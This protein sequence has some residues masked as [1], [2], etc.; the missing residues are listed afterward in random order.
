[1]TK[2]KAHP[3]LLSDIRKYGKFDVNGC[4]SCGSCT[5]SCALSTDFAS[6]PRRMMRYVQ[7]GLKDEV[8][9]GLEPW[10]CYFCGDCSE[11][12]PREADPGESMMTLRRYLTAQYD[13]TG[14]SGKI[15]RSKLWE[16]GTLVLVAAAVLVLG[17]LVHQS[18][19]TSWLEKFLRADLSETHPCL[20]FLKAFDWTVLFLIAFFVLS[21]VIRM[22]W[23]TV[24]RSG[25]RVP[26]T[27]YVTELKTLFYHAFSQVGFRRCEG[28]GRRWISHLLLASGCGV[29]FVLVFGF[30]DWFQTDSVYPVTHPQRWLGYLATGAILFGAGDALWGRI[31]KR[32][33]VH[34]TS[35][36]G[37][38]VLPVLLLLTAL[39][40][41][42]IHILRYAEQY[43]WSNDLYAAHMAVAV[44]MLLVE[45]PFGKWAHMFYRPLAVYFQAL[46]ERAQ[47]PAAVPTANAEPAQKVA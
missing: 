32:E 28:N 42:L 36:L 24:V 20:P 18:S 38:W 4:Y 46:K 16:L 22:Y 35:E 1:M 5:L 40:G 25:V 8:R 27:A 45:I 37:D 2:S 14:L 39:T 23:F 19:V 17:Y 11:T 13:W 44:P 47:A 6:F 30:L 10:L 29:M 7:F 43:T 3:K 31:R 21:N 9:G 12:C 34:Q 33:P 15:F 26:I 41:I